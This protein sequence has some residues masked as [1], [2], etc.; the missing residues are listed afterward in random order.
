MEVRED[1]VCD[2]ERAR[3]RIGWNIVS[4]ERNER[5]GVGHSALAGLDLTQT[6]RAETE[7]VGA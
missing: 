1:T 6:L 7:R 5:G 2:T 4:V 3:G